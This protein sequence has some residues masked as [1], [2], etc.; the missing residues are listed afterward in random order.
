MKGYASINELAAFMNVSFSTSQQTI[1]GLAL[2]AAEQ[3]L[4]AAIKH[5]WL[6]TGPVTED[7]LIGRTSLLRVTKPPV[8]AFTTVSVIWW[9][10]GTPTA[11]LDG[12]CGQFHVR[13]LRD[14]VVWVPYVAGAYA[15]RFVYEPNDDS[16]PDEIKLAVMALASS[17]LR[18]LPLFNDDVDPMLVERYVVGGELEVQFRKNILTT[19]GAAQQALSYVEQWTKGFVLI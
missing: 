9:P 14:G 17:N 8:K 10:S 11:P 5:A 18:T 6:E 19:G 13:S 2:G 16:V 7:V 4:D 1:A 15:V 3:W 12:T